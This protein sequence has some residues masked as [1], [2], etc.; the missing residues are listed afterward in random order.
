MNERGHITTD[1]INFLK[2]NKEY[3]N[4]PLCPQKT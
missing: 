2:D 1:P 4:K 3:S